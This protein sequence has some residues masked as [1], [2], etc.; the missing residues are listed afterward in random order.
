MKFVRTVTSVLIGKAKN[1]KKTTEQMLT[2]LHLNSE[3][4][5]KSQS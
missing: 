3:T 1:K 2:R 5:N 4:L